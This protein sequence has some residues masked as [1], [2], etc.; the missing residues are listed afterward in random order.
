MRAAFHQVAFWT[1]ILFDAVF[2]FLC[3]EEPWVELAFAILL[4]SILGVTHSARALIGQVH[5]E[6]GIVL[7]K[8][9]VLTVLCAA[10]FAAAAFTVTF[11]SPGPRVSTI[12]WSLLIFVALSVY[13]FSC[14]IDRNA[15]EQRK[16]KTKSRKRAG[17]RRRAK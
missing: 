15:A 1:V 9:A 8:G 5:L 11:Y 7:G 10:I 6:K 12:K 16:P 14:L 13:G 2:G 3:A 4:A 17:K